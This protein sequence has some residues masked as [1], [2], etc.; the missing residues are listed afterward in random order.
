MYKIFR[1]LFLFTLFSVAIEAVGNQQFYHSFLQP[2]FHGQRLNYCMLGNGGCG[3]TVAQKYCHLMGYKKANKYIKANNVGLTN[4]IN[5]HWHCKGWRCDGFD[6]ILC[7]DDISHPPAKSY[8]YRF[9]RYAFPRHENYRV[10]W[11]YKAH[12][13]CGYRAANAF[14]H[15][16]GYMQVKHYEKETQVA[17]TKAIGDKGLCFGKQ[18]NSFRSIQ[19][20]R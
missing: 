7:S 15:H 6:L 14:C 19:C 11:C 17:A 2:M 13:G 4:Y 1:I 10:A 16:K 3:D 5:S 9:K 8:H 20:Q 12:S 18:C